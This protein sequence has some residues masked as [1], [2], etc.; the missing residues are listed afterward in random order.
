MKRS[1]RKPKHGPKTPEGAK[2][3][4]AMLS[5]PEQQKATLIVVGH[6]RCDCGCGTPP[7]VSIHTSAPN[8]DCRSAES[9]GRIIESLQAA[10][11]AVFGPP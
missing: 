7:S 3:S 5:G 6:M 11:D 2:F 4:E 10:R 9:L 1:E 8:L